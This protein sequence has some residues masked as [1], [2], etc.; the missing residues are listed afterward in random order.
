MIDGTHIFVD[1]DKQ[2]IARIVLKMA[3]KRSVKNLSTC[4]VIML[5]SEKPQC[6]HIVLVESILD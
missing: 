5:M 6:P 1:W 2:I 3:Q 4:F